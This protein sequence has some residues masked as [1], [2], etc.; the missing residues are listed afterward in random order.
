[1]FRY[2]FYYELDSVFALKHHQINVMFRSHNDTTHQLGPGCRRPHRAP[3]REVP[4]T[5]S[6][7]PQWHADGS[8]PFTHTQVHIKLHRLLHEKKE[9]KKKK[10]HV[11]C[12]VSVATWGLICAAFL[13]S[14]M[15]TCSKCLRVCCLSF[16]SARTY[17]F[18]RL[19]T[20][21]GY[22]RQ[23]EGTRRDRWLGSEEG[24]GDAF[25]F[26]KHSSPKSV[27]NSA[28]LKLSSA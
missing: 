23:T 6:C 3:C 24:Q 17:F 27:S 21:R 15:R 4:K 12:C 16:C 22:E 7:A 28:L 18:N 26:V 13:G 20:W 5:G 10:P 8:V 25:M 11:C 14:T 19:K 1:M 9:K 2:S